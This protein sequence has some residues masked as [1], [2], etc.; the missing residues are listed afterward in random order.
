MLELLAEELRVNGDN[1]KRI[2]KWIGDLRAQ[3]EWKTKEVH[4][5]LS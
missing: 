2:G 1:G 5:Q 3:F 4:R